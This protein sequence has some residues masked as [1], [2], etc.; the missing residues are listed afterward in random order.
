MHNRRFYKIYN[1]IVLSEFF[2]DE[3]NGIFESRF[4]F[5]RK[6]KFFIAGNR[7]MSFVRAMIH[8]LAASGFLWAIGQVSKAKM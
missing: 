3:L 1:Y 4:L 8:N 2:V 7:A 5:G 6:N